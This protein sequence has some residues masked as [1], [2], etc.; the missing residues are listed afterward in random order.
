[1]KR[2]QGLLVSAALLA[3][4][5]F[6]AASAAVA[7]ELQAVQTYEPQCLPESCCGGPMVCNLVPIECSVLIHPVRRIKLASPCRPTTQARFASADVDGCTHEIE[8]GLLLSDRKAGVGV[9]RFGDG[10]DPRLDVAR[11]QPPLLELLSAFRDGERLVLVGPA[12]KAR[13]RVAPVDVV[14]LDARTGKLE[15]RIR[16]PSSRLPLSPTARQ[17]VAQ[18]VDGYTWSEQQ[19]LER[20]RCMVSSR[21]C[22]RSGPPQDMV[23]DTVV[24]AKADA[25]ADPPRPP[26]DEVSL[27]VQGDRVGLLPAGS[28][29]GPTWILKTDSERQWRLD[30]QRRIDDG[31]IALLSENRYGMQASALARLSNEGQPVGPPISLGSDL[32]ARLWSCTAKRCLVTRE[33]RDGSLEALVVDLPAVKPMEHEPPGPF[34]DKCK[35]GQFER[36]SRQ[37]R[38]NR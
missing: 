24:D 28:R 3:A 29:R 11:L 33:A 21:G 10:T 16:W 9:I 31:S 23:A 6:A 36:K 26:S 18:I 12:R 17:R 7:E 37:N 25:Q 13:D 15:G 14:W 30:G 34:G 38:G 20:A 2:A 32:T 19:R 1:M 4:S 35:L 27:V 5:L 8:P 22:P